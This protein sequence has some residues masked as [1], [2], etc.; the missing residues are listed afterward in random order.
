[1]IEKKEKF[2]L[3]FLLAATFFFAAYKLSEIPPPWYDEGYIIQSSINL[4][5]NGQ[6][7]VRV[8]PDLVLEN[9]T[10]S[11]GYP[12]TY[13]IGLAIKFWGKGIFQA[14]SVMVPF[15]LFLVLF[16]YLLAKRIWG[17]RVAVFSSLLIASFASL[18]GNGKNVLGEVPGIFFLVLFLFFIHRIEKDNYG[19]GHFNYIMAGLS[20]GL[21][22]STKSIFLVLPGAILVGL[23]LKR[24]EII[25]WRPEIFSGLLA[26]MATFAVLIKTQFSKI[27]S[28]SK[29]FTEYGNPYAIVDMKS[30]ILSNITRFF[31]E[32]TP[33]YF[34]IIL[35]IWILAILIRTGFRKERISLTEYIAFI[36]SI[37][38]W[39]SYLRMIGWYRYLFSA[40]IIMLLFFPSAVFMVFEYAASFIKKR[41]LILNI[42]VFILGVLIA[43]QFY[44]LCFSS[45]V[46]GYKDSS[47]TRDLRRYFDNYDA[48]KEIFLYN[49]PELAVF[50]PGGNYYQYLR[51]TDSLILGQDQL[52]KIDKGIPDEIIFNKKGNEDI[53][54]F[55]LY[56]ERDR[57]SKYIILEKIK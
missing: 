49:A 18:Y 11:T 19:S 56:K 20:A 37:L 9:T 35:I 1:M 5:Q 44:Q 46:S 28:L 32:I 30:L 27:D 55:S 17:F 41:R 7:G 38:I 36:F 48:S 22:I 24:K 8:A 47:N 21:C 26:L 15:M 14:R 57:I 42:P 2:F 45:W 4:V 6:M 23:F 51:I 54:K 3:F 53:T 13:L 29:I 12:L 50:L 16:S 39:L 43:S 25:M 52:D 34:L 10:F 33:I 31:T 40:Q